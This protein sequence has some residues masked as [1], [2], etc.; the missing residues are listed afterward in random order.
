MWGVVMKK[1]KK[2]FC[3]ARLTNAFYNHDLIL[4]KTVMRETY[5]YDLTI[6][7]IKFCLMYIIWIRIISFTIENINAIIL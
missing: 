7:V 4:T 5:Y 3:L 6:L 1:Y 2:I